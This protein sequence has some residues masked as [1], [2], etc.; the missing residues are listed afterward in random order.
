[1]AMA[2]ASY[3]AS[4]RGL[5]SRTISL[6]ILAVSVARAG[7]RVLTANAKDFARIAEF[8]KFQWEILR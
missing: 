7:I 8:R 6:R 4:L 5:M 1:M 3:N 2:K